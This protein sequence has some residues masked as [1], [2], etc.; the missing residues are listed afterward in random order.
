MNPS[1]VESEVVQIS[2]STQ[3]SLQLKR[4]ALQAEIHK[5]RMELSRVEWEL[6]VCE[7]N[8]ASNAVAERLGVPKD[9]LNVTIDLSEGVIHYGL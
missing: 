1:D 9:A 6:A 5:K 7:S 2:L 8:L 4:L 3:D